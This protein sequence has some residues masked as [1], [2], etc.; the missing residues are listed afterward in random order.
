MQHDSTLK[1]TFRRGTG[2]R[3]SWFAALLFAAAV[4]AFAAFDDTNILVE[5]AVNHIYQ[6][7][8]KQAHQALQR[9][10]E[11][12]PRHPGV[13]F[14]LARV[15]ELTGNFQEALKEYQLAAVL[16]P[17]MVAAR[18]GIAR[19]TVEMKRSRGEEQAAVLEDAARERAARSQQR[20]QQPARPQRTTQAPVVTRQNTPDLPV[21]PPTRPPQSVAALP[22]MP[23]SSQLPPAETLRVPPL[24]PQAAQK[25]KDSIKTS[26]ESR[27]E[28]FIERG[29]YQQAIELLDSLSTDD[30]DNPRLH[31]LL[32]KAFSLKGD[33]FAS[34]KHL[35]EAIRVDE[36]FHA[37]YYLLAQNY[38]K[39]NLLD[40]ALK[41]YQTY[42]A[43]KPQAGV[44]VEIA[45]IYE[46]MGRADLAKEYYAKANSMNPG[47]PNLQSRL[48]QASIDV[49]NDLY[50]R[51]SQAFTTGDFAGA[52]TLFEQA[53]A[54]GGLDSTYRR[55]AQRKIEIARVRAAEAEE[56]ARP[57]REGFAASRKI[58][59][60]TNLTYRQLQDI[61]FKTRFTGSVTLEWRG[62]VARTM[63]R[64]GLDF[65]LMIK[66]LSQE[67][68]DQMGRD[69][70]DFRLSPGFNNQPVFLV[71]APKGGLPPFAK[72]GA[73]LNV[74]GRAEW[75]SYR[76]IND[77][78]QSVELPAI[79]YI[80]AHP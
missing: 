47:N 17:S 4:P 3:H 79:E 64:Y 68:L 36:H 6:Q 72:Q 34:I 73:V 39:V 59:A 65:L 12:S 10:Y 26:A 33:L 31:Y 56:I 32:G 66:E 55:D 40:D 23:P 24:P 48:D 27:A 25:A 11:R 76:V 67:E 14:N 42:F 80:A 41:N 62:Y 16:D 18:R 21:L 78:G 1:T 28:D 35:E 57:A 69:R 22:A 53:L 58:Y 20:S 8:Y 61:N 50:L 52:V 9:A 71:A 54:G 51:A 37:A 77:L 49:A 30:E 45:R 63:S 7:R 38:S 75:K 5:E 44:A 74:T 70:N 46:R 2:T 19:C 60:S 29:R 13:H 15:F 43:V